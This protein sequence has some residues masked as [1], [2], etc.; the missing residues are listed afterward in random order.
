MRR[1]YDED[2]FDPS[3]FMEEL[4]SR[5]SGIQQSYDTLR[6]GYSWVQHFLREHPGY[7]FVEYSLLPDAVEVPDLSEARVA[8]VSM[9]GI[10]TEDQKAFSVTP[11]EV[12]P[13][14]LVQGFREMGDSSLREISNSLPPSS[15]RISYPYLDITGAGE[16]INTIFPITRLQAL[17]EESFIESISDVHLSFMGYLPNPAALERSTESAVNL[18]SENDVNLVLFAPADIL[19]HQTMAVLQRG[20]EAAG[21]ATISVALC[22]DVVES[23]GVPRAVHYRFPFGYTFGGANDETMQLRILKE[24]LRSGQEIDQ[25]G[26]IVDLPYEWMDL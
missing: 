8:L 6:P 15:L 5:G 1:D 2:D 23:I 17:E 7:E 18:L 4:P 14:Y 26:M 12:E 13:E 3:G 25:A 20:L 9:A 24:T 10:H 16:D 19:S 21:I 22:R 11:G